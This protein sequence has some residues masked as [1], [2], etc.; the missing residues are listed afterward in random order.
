[1][2]TFGVKTKRN[3]NLVSIED[4]CAMTVNGGGLDLDLCLLMPC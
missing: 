4:Q 3:M 1:M 2:N